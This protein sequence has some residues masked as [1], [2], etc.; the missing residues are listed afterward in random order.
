MVERRVCESGHGTSRRP[1]VIT[2]YSIHYTKL[3]DVA[4]YLPTLFAGAGRFDT[5]TTEAVALSA[6]GNRPV[7]AVQSLLQTGL[8]LLAFGLAALW[9]RWRARRRRGLA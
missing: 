2:S 9:P 7:L 6:G 5:V 3:Y 1:C 4:Q 8:P